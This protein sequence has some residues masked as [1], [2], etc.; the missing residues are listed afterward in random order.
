M[1][2]IEKNLKKLK[3]FRWDWETQIDSL[4]IF[5]NKKNINILILLKILEFKIK[6]YKI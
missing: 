6:D 5:D 1:K 4:N 3:R 2:K